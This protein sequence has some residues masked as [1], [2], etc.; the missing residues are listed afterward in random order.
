MSLT[1]HRVE[2]VR[3]E[4]LTSRDE[5]L[6]DLDGVSGGSLT[7][8][9]SAVLPGSGSFT[10]VERGQSINYSSNRI[11]PWWRVNGQEWP[12]GVFVM[13]APTVAH[14]ESSTSRQVTLI[15]KLTVVKEDALLRTFQLAA[16]TNIIDAAVALLVNIGETRV[17]ATASTA[18]LTNA[19]TWYPGTSRLQVI[20]DLLAAAGYAN[21]WT[22]RNGVYRI[23]PYIAPASRPIVW[24]F[25]EGDTAIHTPDWQYELALWEA[26]NT[27]IMTSQA[28]DAGSVYMATAVDN[29][30]ASPTSTVSMGR[31]LNPI[32]VENVEASSQGDLEAQALRTLLDASNVAGRLRVTHAAVPV[33]F[34]DAVRFVSQG[35]DTSATI[36]RM[37]LELTP[38]SLVSAEWRQA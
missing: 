32:V 6:G 26:S 35:T 23:E 19:M 15:D 34:D 11:R 25:E 36:S 16:G 21:L 31:T 14:G 20:N 37:S 8:D 22:D 3:V 4:L 24:S 13:A 28:T 30:P 1:G 38:G 27:V 5:S 17:S 18:V 9:S 10:L 7:W 33:W 29:N 12:L 2:S